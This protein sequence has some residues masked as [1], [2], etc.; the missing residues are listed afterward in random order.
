MSEYRAPIRDMQFVLNELAGL[1]ELAKLPGCEEAT[2]DVVDAILEE[3]AKFAEEVLSPLNASGD[4]EGARFA[5]GKVTTPKGF[6][7]AYKLFAESGW[8]ALGCEPEWGGQG[9]PRLVATPV[10]EMWKSANHAFSLCPLLTG[11]AI[12][13][14]VL[15]GSDELKKTFLEKMVTGEWTGTMNL[16]EPGAGSDLAAVRTRAEP[17]PDGS[18]RVFGQKIFIT[19]GEHDMADNIVHLVLART[20]TAPEGVKGISLFIVPKFIVNADGSLGERNDAWCASI[21]HKLGIHA[22]PTAV[23]AFGDHG[24]AVGY[25]VGEENHGLEYMFVMMN[26]ARFGVGMEG[27]SVSERA[28]QRARN[29]AQ[30]RLQGTDVGVRGGPRVPIIVHP[31]VRRMLM[32][33]RA[34]AEASRALAYVVASKHDAA[35]CHPDPDQRKRNQAFVDLMIPVV[36]GWSTEIGIEVASLGIQVHGGMGYMEE[37]GAAQ[38]LRDSRI[39]TI[40]EGTTGIQANDLVGRKM[41]RDGGAVFKE[42]IEMMRAVEQALAASG[43]ADIKAIR[44]RLAVAIDALLRAGTWIVEEFP[45]DTRAALAS[46]V[47][48]LRLFGVVAAGWQM[49]RAAA[50]AQARVDAGDGDPFYQAKVYTARFFA[51]HLLTQAE[52]LA[53]TVVDGAVSTMA[54]PV[55]QF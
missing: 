1:D 52:G 11:G 54:M 28:Y 20:P 38:Y 23:M 5:D 55:D 42:V 29:Y 41:A 51:D 49:A 2:P 37:T 47:P 13:A 46:A 19:Y 8:T 43:S 33:M 16:T 53:T 9:L 12:D 36:K 7:E 6:K 40:Y 17:Q 39:S 22:S 3:A 44:E 34:Q 27:V 14:L 24:G 4:K 48:F 25:L 18:Y 32:T 31:D 21:E 50:I 15:S 26:V 10:A 30:E 35:L 45:K